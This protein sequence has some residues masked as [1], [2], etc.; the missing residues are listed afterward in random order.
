MKTLAELLIILALCILFGNITGCGDGCKAD[1]II[2]PDTLI[3]AF[4]GECR[5]NVLYKADRDGSKW[6]DD[7]GAEIA[8]DGFV[9]LTPSEVEEAYHVMRW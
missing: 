7:N 3:P 6:L 4:R 5:D 2:T 1:Y 8:C 9:T